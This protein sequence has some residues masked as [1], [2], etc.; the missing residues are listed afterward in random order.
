[1]LLYVELVISDWQRT[2][3]QKTQWKKTPHVRSQ[4]F[5]IK[6]SRSEESWHIADLLF[7]GE[8]EEDDESTPNIG[9]TFVYYICHTGRA[10]RGLMSDVEEQEEWNNTK[11]RRR[12]QE[13]L[14]ERG[15]IFPYYSVWA[16]WEYSPWKSPK[17]NRQE[18]SLNAF[19]RVNLPTTHVHQMHP[20]EEK[21]LP[22]R[23]QTR[24]RWRNDYRNI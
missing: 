19:S 5:P 22:R 4:D 9:D 15:I 11:R 23:R 7:S 21:P 6:S 3:N 2:K 14:P 20:L 12:G 10:Q 8:E 17:N 1:M 13:W 18:W 24:G 16:F